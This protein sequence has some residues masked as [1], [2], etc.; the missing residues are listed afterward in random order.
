MAMSLGEQLRA[1]RLKR[2]LTPSQVAAR[3][4]M[5][6]A[7]VEAIEQDDFA[8]MPAPIYARGFIRMYA[9]Q[10][11]LDP[12]PLLA[13]YA[14]RG[15]PRRVTAVEPE[16]VVMPA[17]AVR[18]PPAPAAAVEETVAPPA[19]AEHAPSPDAAAP[20]PGSE[21]DPFL[22]VRR[23]ESERE[24]LRAGMGLSGDGRNMSPVA[25]EVGETVRSFYDT[26]AGAVRGAKERLTGPARRAWT[27]PRFRPQLILALLGILILVLFAVSSLV[28]CARKVTAA[29]PPAT[30]DARAALH[31]LEPPAAYVD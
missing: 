6:T 21:P 15:Q 19:E 2:N 8:K 27:W 9:L 5:K 3:T 12:A 18:E 17:P 26:L 7:I 11:G 16:R 4:H 1:A 22:E 10:V 29:P 14:A 13:E 30:S 24:S 28:R 31:A 23:R 25:A 20:G